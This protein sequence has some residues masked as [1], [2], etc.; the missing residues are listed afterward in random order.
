MGV[1]GVSS[2][3]AEAISIH[4]PSVR[5]GRRIRRGKIFAARTTVTG[6]PENLL[7]T[8]QQGPLFHLAALTRGPASLPHRMRRDRDEVPG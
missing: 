8:G 7:T 5:K 2:S 1:L 4:K 6:T 3:T